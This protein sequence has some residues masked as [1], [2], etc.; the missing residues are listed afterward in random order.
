MTSSSQRYEELC[1]S[2]SID[3]FDQLHKELSKIL[4]GRYCDEKLIFFRSEVKFTRDYHA[5]HVIYKIEG[6]QTESGPTRYGRELIL[7]CSHPKETLKAT[8]LQFNKETYVAPF[9]FSG[10]RVKLSIKGIKGGVEGT[11]EVVNG[12]SIIVQNW[13]KSLIP[14][15]LQCLG[16]NIG[17]VAFMATKEGT[18]KQILSVERILIENIL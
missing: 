13:V 11:F 7:K 4:A 16:R 12:S 14:K 9:L 3:R 1:G 6:P 10:E 18:D 2:G 5:G 17:F 15:K 8:L